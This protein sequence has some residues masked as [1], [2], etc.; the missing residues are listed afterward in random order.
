MIFTILAII[1]IIG[2][3]YFAYL[4]RQIKSCPVCDYPMTQDN[5]DKERVGYSWTCGRCKK[6]ILNEEI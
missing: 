2:L 1:S 3:I 4:E 6:R 5:I